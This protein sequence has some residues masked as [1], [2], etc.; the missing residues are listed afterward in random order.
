M[1]N[2]QKITMKTTSR[3]LNQQKPY[4]MLLELTKVTFNST[5]KILQD[6][7]LHLLAEGRILILVMQI[8]SLFCLCVF[9]YAF[10]DERSIT[11]RYN[12]LSLNY[13]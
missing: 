8:M 9:D 1:Q 12:F 7:L 13:N 2:G 5:M 6:Q 10:H 3:Y 4:S 11:S